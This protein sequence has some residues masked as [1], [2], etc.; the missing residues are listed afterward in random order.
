MIQMKIKFEKVTDVTEFVNEVSKLE[1]EVDLSSGRYLINAKSIM[2]LFTLNLSSPIDLIIH[3]EDM[4]LKN[5][6]NK[7]RVE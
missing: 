6:F 1:C 2:G 7:W 3:S 5:K 4:E